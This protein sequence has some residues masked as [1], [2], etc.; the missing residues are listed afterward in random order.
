MILIEP[1]CTD[2]TFYFAVEE[3]IM[4]QIRP[5]DAALMFWQ[6]QPTIVLGRNQIAAAE[7]DMELAEQLGVCVVRR[8][9]GG[10]AVFN[11]L[12]TLLCT[13]ITPWSQGCDP[14]NVA[15]RLLVNPIME[16]LAHLGVT[17][18]TQG[19]NDIVVDGRKISGIAQYIS[20]GYLCSHCSLLYTNDLGKL[21][22]LLT[23]DEGKI[24]SKA[25][26]S[27][28]SRVANICEF[29]S[30]GISLRDFRV[31]LIKAWD[32]IYGDPVRYEFTVEE[33]DT[34][35]TIRCKKYA[36]DEWIIG[37]TPT[38]TFT[39][40]KR[41]PGGKIE[42]FLTI[43]KGRI[44]GCDIKGDFLSFLP[45]QEIAE[46]MVGFP[47]DIKHIRKVLSDVYLP[48]YIGGISLDEFLTVLFLR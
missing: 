40:A 4:K 31:H 22:K 3:Y 41:F 30:D 18:E 32:S 27:V 13:V 8:P 29:I 35:E 33:R 17:A 21:E 47:Y 1:K 44:A 14:K 24:A 5:Q 25:L 28:R 39:N 38:F 45:V 9:S 23:V 20:Y 19:R 10:G 42:V 34:I 15:Y 26:R 36:C 12:G 16:T 6:I 37:R 7:F 11:D 2:A 46:R 48:L 43:E